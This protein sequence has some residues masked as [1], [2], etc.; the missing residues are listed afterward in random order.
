M[1]C[2]LK[3]SPRNS[4]FPS[5]WLIETPSTLPRADAWSVTDSL[6]RSR[7]A[8][9]QLSSLTSSLFLTHIFASRIY[10]GYHR[11]R[12]TVPESERASVPRSEWLRSKLYI[13]FSTTTS[14][15]TLAVKYAF[16]RLGTGIWKG[17]HGPC[18]LYGSI[19]WPQKDLSYFDVF[20]VAVFFQLV[21][22]MAIRLAHHSFTLG[23][24]GLASFGAVI[25]FMESLHVTIAK[26]GFFNEFR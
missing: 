9:V 8:L 6:H 13:L 19:S 7:L 12:K 22:Y 25:L 26:V 16:V 14:F 11:S 5:S 23:E 15:V 4:H 18:I 10:E 3:S 20:S 17:R 1:N 2:E 21:L 24:L